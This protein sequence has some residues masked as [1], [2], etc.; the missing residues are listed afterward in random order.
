M[1]KFL[2]G[3]V[4]MMSLMTLSFATAITPDGRG[5]WHKVSESQRLKNTC[6]NPLEDISKFAC[7]YTWN[8]VVL[9][10]WY[11]VEFAD[12]FFAWKQDRRLK[13][14]CA[15][16]IEPK[17][18]GNYNNWDNPWFEKTAEISKSSGFIEKQKDMLI[19]KTKMDYQIRKHPEKRSSNN[20]MVKYVVEYANDKAGTT[21]YQHTECYPYI[22]SRCWD[23]V[24]D[25]DWN[26]RCDKDGN[27]KAAEEC[28]P[29]SPEWKNRLDWKT[30]SSTCKITEPKDPVCG[31]SYNNRTEYTDSS[32]EWLK[33][34][35]DKLCDEWTVD[36]FS[37][38]PKTWGPRTYTWNCKNW[39]KIT[40]QSCKA[41][42]EWCGD[43]VKN[44]EEDC[45]DGSKNG[46]SASSCS[47]T[48]TTVGSAECWQENGSKRYFKN[49]KQ[50]TPWLT[51]KSEKMCADGQTVGKPIMVGDHIEWTC[52]NKNG[53]ERTC[54]AYQEWCGDEIKN[55]EEDC[56]WTDLCDFQ[57]KT[58]TP[59]KDCVDVFKW[60]LRLWKEHTFSDKFKAGWKD[61]YLYYWPNDVKFVENHWD[62]GDDPKFEWTSELTKQWNK[63][64]ANTEIVVMKSNPYKAIYKPTVR[65]WDNIYL[66]YTIWYSD[67]YKTPIPSKSNLY[68]SKECAY[69][70]ITRCGDGKLDEDYWEECD[71]GSEWT[72]VLPDG[73]ICNA[74]CKIEEPKTW[75]LNV[76]KT[77]QEKK[78]VKKVGETL[79]WDVKVTAVWWDVKNV[80]I[81]DYLPKELSYVSYDTKLPTGIK[82]KSNQPTKWTDKDGDY[83]Q[84]QTEWTLKKWESFVLTL[85][86]K[87]EVMPKADDDIKNVACA[88]PENN[89]EDKECGVAQPPERRVEKTLLSP[90]EIT[91]VW[92]EVVW[93]LKL[94]VDKWE[95]KDPVIEDILPPVLWYKKSEIIHHPWIKISDAKQW[96]VF[97]WNQNL[98]KI[99]WTT[100][101]TVLSWDYIEIKLTTY[102]KE[103][104]T[105]NS[106]NVVCAHPEDDPDDE[107][108]AP[109]EFGPHLWIK[110]YFLNADGTKTKE[111][112]KV[113]VWDE[114]TYR[115]EFGN[116]GKAK[117][118][119][120]MIKDFLPKNVT[121]VWVPSIHIDSV[122][123]NTLTPTNTKQEKDEE[124]WNGFKVVDGVDIEFYDWITLN[125]GDKWYITMTVKISDT[126]LDNRTNFACIYLNGEKIDCDNV[127][128]E[129]QQSLSC[130]PTLSPATFA[131]VCAGDTSTFSTEVTCKSQWWKAE[132][133]I[134]CDD[135]IVSYSTWQVE[136]LTWTCSSN[137]NGTAHKVQCMINGSTKW[138][139]WEI[140]E[141]SFRRN[142]KSCWSPSSCFIAWTKVLM[143]DG[144]EK[145]IED[146]EEW[147]YVMW[148]TW[149]NKVRWF[150]RPTLG[151]RN[152][153]KI[154]GE[155]DYFVSDEHP[156]K[157]TDW[158][159]SFNP[160]MTRKEI[161]Y[162][163]KN[164]YLKGEL[165]IYGELKI[166]DILYTKTGTTK[167]TSLEA[168]EG[169][170]NTQLYN[171]MLDGDHT[172]YAN[173][174]LVHNKGWSSWGW[175]K[176]PSCD[177]IKID[178]DGVT[179]SSKNAT[180]YFKLECDGNL[181]YSTNKDLDYKFRECKNPKNAKCYVSDSKNSG[182]ETN[183]T[184]TKITKWTQEC[185]NVNAWNFSIEE[186]EILP[187]YRNLFNM[188]DWV[189]KNEA[190]YTTIEWHAYKNAPELYE[191]R[192]NCEDDEAWM[193]ALNSMVCTFNIYN[194]KS[195]KTPLYT[196]EW[197]CLTDPKSYPLSTTPI[198][199][200]WYQAMK[201]TYC[202]D[203]S[204]KK[205]YFS[206]SEQREWK[207]GA[208]LN[209]AVYYIENFWSWASLSLN[210]K[211]W[212]WSWWLTYNKN[213]ENNKLY[214]EYQIKLESV[215]Y[216]QCD[217]DKWQQVDATDK[218]FAPCES[219]FVLTNSYT[220]QK[221]P[222]WNLTASTTK[223]G[224]Y[225]N[226]SGTV[227]FSSYINAIP[228]T[229]YSKNTQV[230]NAMDSFIK[231][232]EKLAV[233]V[234]TNKFWSNLIVKKVPWKD[235]YFLSGNANFN[236]NTVSTRP[237]TIVQTSGNVTIN[238]DFDHNMML[239]T[240]N[241][242]T[243]KGDCTHEYDQTVRWIFY[244]WGKLIRGWVKRNDNVDNGFWCRSGWLHIKWVL[245]WDGFEWLMNASRSHLNNW[246]EKT[247]KQW[248]I[249]N[250]ASVLIEYSP[251]VFTKSTMPP[252][253]EDFTTALSIY[254]N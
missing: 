189:E 6:S 133:K 120:T 170:P 13:T 181:Y 160:A 32:E 122:P 194:G 248:E 29:E 131:D 229:T 5:E 233:K 231:K 106:K 94:T 145:N 136:Q 74:D 39:P 115:I 200:Y 205:C 254:K 77:L 71:P 85:K 107:E 232:Y 250:W 43:W 114:V 239:L 2:L 27:C 179:C 10:M 72:K 201:E 196:V 91:K 221:T 226:L 246:F 158:W 198:L 124:L 99:T 144:T 47:K 67:V 37:F 23:G 3:S 150:D 159:K 105:Q 152:L 96:T 125:V 20:L 88:H 63:V 75:K 217:W 117:A 207:K 130:K 15:G 149:P 92:E 135:K 165:P 243:F 209:S 66:E 185:F 36:G 251:S 204:S 110:K 86:T 169:D 153:W 216:L 127:V 197:P 51:E 30:C 7:D 168:E 102:V 199:S 223:L 69:Y 25:N 38:S 227:A 240:K 118:S 103:M 220:V 31:S 82:M 178:S 65:A 234:D 22:I 162:A 8:P 56:D 156:F 164:G 68:S 121:L 148:E 163:Q 186:W 60:K 218:E 70:E 249:M 242:I 81:K 141:G 213:D 35:T 112:K 183:S 161:E 119:V 21:R 48:C 46:T 245:I 173:G 142:T 95:L 132:I 247:D 154:N 210:G 28:D 228:T 167:I 9:R 89:P 147:E 237:F 171:F 191:A 219:N 55:G 78:Q 116:D 108:C 182:W 87:V 14:Y 93:K 187:F 64:E 83:L 111:T 128:H 54:K 225:R 18:N 98:D 1:K 175:S 16:I 49:G 140:C 45:D 235:I 176:S 230:E 212:E 151:D 188:E 58:I 90:K 137:V 104:P 40:K 97:T 157:T 59:P 19:I 252:G 84:W 42:Q 211:K 180:A 73:R 33:S 129:I 214:W 190:N 206:Y 100:D 139:N 80:V 155:G 61:W 53:T 24:V 202:K 62:Y 253:A 146:V 184:C 76:E 50:T 238:G 244:A 195:S 44:G 79:T 174:Y 193:I 4:F 113:K 41:Y 17:D 224:N 172:Y 101:W 26:W 34:T 177:T 57:C 192:P 123:D 134:L 109:V 126:Y 52:S 241:N 11:G 208:L 222:S 166:W 236:P 143:A 12:R 215:K 203:S 138:E